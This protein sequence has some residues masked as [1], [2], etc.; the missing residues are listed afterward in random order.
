MTDRIVCIGEYMLGLSRAAHDRMTF[1]YGGDTLNTAVCFARLG[2][3]T[4]SPRLKTTRTAT[5]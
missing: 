4:M 5:G 2:R 1:S 3:S